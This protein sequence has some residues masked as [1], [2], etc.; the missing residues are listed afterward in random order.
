MNRVL[1]T[2]LLGLALMLGMSAAQAAG[3]PVAGQK[4]AQACAA[5]HGA[6]GNSTVPMYPKLAGQYRNYL[7][8][9]L[10]AYKTGERKNPIMVGMA[11]SLSDQDIADLAAWFSSQEGLYDT[12]A[13]KAV[14]K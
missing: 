7:E 5:C 2:G 9:A 13:P 11:A 3:D 14:K 8:H 1:W 12:P 6:D 10:K 4:K